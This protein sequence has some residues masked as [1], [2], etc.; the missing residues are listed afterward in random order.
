MCVI[1]E[2]GFPVYA[3][4]VGT[5]ITL[6]YPGTST[7]DIVWW[8]GNNRLV[9]NG[10]IILELQDRIHLNKSTGDLTIDNVTL[11]DSGV[12]YSGG[13]FDKKQ[14]INVTVI[15]KCL[16]FWKSAMLLHCRPQ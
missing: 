13:R 7:A 2:G 10:E 15:G 9:L 3:P 16:S 8:H 4:E 6:L 1:F 12:Y 5:N 11:A 14:V